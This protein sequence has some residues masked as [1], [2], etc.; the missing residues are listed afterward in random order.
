VVAV[1]P[2][3]GGGGGLGQAPLPGQKAGRGEGQYQQQDVLF[4][5]TDP[6][7]PWR[8]ADHRQQHQPGAGVYGLRRRDGQRARIGQGALKLALQE[9]EMPEE[10]SD[11]TAARAARAAQSEQGAAWEDTGKGAVWAKD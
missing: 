2:I 4:L 9:W 10:P 3:P 7:G 8:E 1:E 5:E 6:A 11:P